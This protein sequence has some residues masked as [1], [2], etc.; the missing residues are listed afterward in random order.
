MISYSI[1]V[2]LTKRERSQFGPLISIQLKATQVES[3]F[4]G[5]PEFS[6]K[7]I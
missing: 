2:F 1:L 7:T 4:E 6:L 5:R 3:T